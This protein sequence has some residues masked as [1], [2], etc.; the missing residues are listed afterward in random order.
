LATY[1]EDEQVLEMDGDATADIIALPET[2][3]SAR[4]HFS[5]DVMRVSLK[6]GELSVTK[7]RLH[8]EG[9]FSPPGQGAQ[10]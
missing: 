3:D 10:Q 8:V 2:A 6:S 7:A 1:R 9:E 4:A 5:G